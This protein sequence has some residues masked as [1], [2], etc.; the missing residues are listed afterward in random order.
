MVFVAANEAKLRPLLQVNTG[1]ISFKSFPWIFLSVSVVCAS[2][3]KDAAFPR[4][5]PAPNTGVAGLVPPNILVLGIFV[6]KIAAVG[7]APNI[8]PDV[9]A[10]EGDSNIL[11]LLDELFS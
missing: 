10:G 11:V 6:P 5:A 3:A 9:L 1:S 2:L 7:F 8:F 4:Y